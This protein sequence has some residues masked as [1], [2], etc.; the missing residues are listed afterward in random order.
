MNFRSLQ[1]RITKW[2]VG[3]MALALLCVWVGVYL[4]VQ[5]F[6]IASQKRNLNNAVNNIES[7]FLS[8]Y[9]TKG[10]N[11]VADEMGDVYAGG[12]DRYVRVRY[13]G[14]EIFTSHDM[15][16][17][18]AP[19]SKIPLPTDE[20]TGLLHIGNGG[21][22][23]LELVDHY[24]SPDGHRFTIIVGAS[25]AAAHRV[26]RSLA[27][28][29]SIVCPLVL[30]V[31]A[32]AC[33]LMIKRPLRPVAVLTEQAEN[34]GRKHLGDRLPVPDT[35]DELQRLATSLNHMIARLEDALQHNN[36]FSADASHELRTPLTIVR[37]EL[38]QVI[39]QP[40]LS[41][42]TVDSIGSALEEIER[43]SQIVQSL[44][45]T[46]YLDT[47]GEQ[48]ECEPTDLGR[49][50]GSTLD[51]M[52]LLAE[53][54]NITL[55]SEKLESALVDGN[56]TRL[57]QVVVNLVDNAMKYNRPNGSVSASVFSKDQAVILRVADTG[58]GIPESSIPFIFDRF[59]RADKT[60]TRT[61]GGIGIGLSLVK[62]ICNAHGA[63]IDVKSRQGKGT[64]FS[65]AFPRYIP[66]TATSEMR[67]TKTTSVSTYAIDGR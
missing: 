37:G 15:S 57:K 16:N 62:A 30:V 43:M 12:A 2:F 59:Y 19:V 53:S 26:L 61:T 27:I 42:A 20:E 45:A 50:V 67:S 8:Q 66:E 65:I 33:F 39:Q 29:L 11:W 56:P 48:M 34:I 28:I 40:D 10:E 22:R 4:S 32:L 58:I 41:E 17:P 54:Q 6:L 21:G 52:R 5:Q 55:A 46:A 47:G 18:Q 38:E 63:T 13:N 64:V 9:G 35:R 24:I 31:A 1:F 49:L 23:L 25:E 7:Q 36:R 14:R 60:R 44:M 51:Q 3:F